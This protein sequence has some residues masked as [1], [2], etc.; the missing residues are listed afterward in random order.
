MAG[1]RGVGGGSWTGTPVY[2]AP[3]GPAI[4]TDV[5]DRFNQ[6][7]GD[8]WQLVGITAAPLV[9]AWT[10]PRGGTAVT[11]YTDKVHFL[12][13]FRRVFVLVAH[14][15]TLHKND[16]KLHRREL[17]SETA[18]VSPVPTSQSPHFDAYTEHLPWSRRR[19][20]PRRRRHISS[21]WDP[22]LPWRRRPRFGGTKQEAKSLR[23]RRGRG[24]LPSGG[25]R[26][27]HLSP[28]LRWRHSR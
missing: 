24:S 22:A 20:R 1:H 18:L 6:L 25:R 21:L 2:P 26:P 7:G 3:T 28:R 9:T 17:R 16:I 15:P 13:A 12:A 11:G 8:G 14:L 10:S 4:T 5:Q 27:P 19:R 23:R